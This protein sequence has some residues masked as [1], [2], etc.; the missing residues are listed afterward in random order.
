MFYR[1]N[2]HTIKIYFNALLRKFQAVDIAHDDDDDDDELHNSTKSN[3][4]RNRLKILAIEQIQNQLN[5]I[6]MQQHSCS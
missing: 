4:N 3:Q 2:T 1:A 6:L 5:E